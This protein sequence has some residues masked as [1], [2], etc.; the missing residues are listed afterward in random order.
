MNT[1]LNEIL[2]LIGFLASHGMVCL[3]L[4]SGC[5][6]RSGTDQEFSLSEPPACQVAGIQPLID[7]ALES[8]DT[9]PLI[10]QLYRDVLKREPDLEGLA[11][12]AGDLRGKLLA[13]GSD[14][15]TAGQN[16]RQDQLLLAYGAF[17]QSSE[18]QVVT[19]YQTMLRR[20]P[21]L[22]GQKFWNTQA[23]QFGIN[24]VIRALLR[25]EE[26]QGRNLLADSR[27][28]VTSLY[29]DFLGRAP[30]TWFWADHLDSQLAS[31]GADAGCE[32]N[33]RVDTVKAFLVSAESLT[34]DV[35]DGMLLRS[36]RYGPGYRSVDPDGARF[37]ANNSETSGAQ[38]TLRAFLE[39]AEFSER[40]GCR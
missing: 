36:E 4:V 40:S 8:F 33:A 26:Y 19:L 13:C 31:C 21:D 25:S 39:S 24:E 35:Y 5:A 3:V 32:E 27:S 12:W 6:N 18:R 11:F 10:S 16:C 23:L 37:W 34:H 38:A 2:R 7:Q 20:N 15:G 28:F 30:E 29:Q 1:H 17:F 22:G 9:A 14:H